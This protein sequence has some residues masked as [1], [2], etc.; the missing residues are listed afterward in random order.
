MLSDKITITCY[1]KALRGKLPQRNLKI[2]YTTDGS[3]PNKQSKC[4][5][6]PF[7]VTA[8]IM[9][10]AVVYDGEEELI[11]MT[12]T[13]GAKEGLYWGKVGEPTCIFH[14]KQTGK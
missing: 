11:R 14:D 6:S 1:E 4:Y 7:S 3:Q 13:F 8:G 2:F 9:V 12:E 5:E 10:K